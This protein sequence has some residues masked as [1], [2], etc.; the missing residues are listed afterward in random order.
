MASCMHVM[1]QTITLPISDHKNISETAANRL[2]VLANL[3]LKR[4]TPSSEDNLVL[5]TGLIM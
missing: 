4:Q 2:L 5:S 1:Q 3:S